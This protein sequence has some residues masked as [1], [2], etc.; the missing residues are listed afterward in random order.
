MTN[1]TALKIKN[2]IKNTLG[3]KTTI[4]NLVYD[5]SKTLHLSKINEYYKE[6]NAKFK[7][8]NFRNIDLL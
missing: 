6:V 2:N 5:F 1:E 4:E 8:F 3:E 7:E